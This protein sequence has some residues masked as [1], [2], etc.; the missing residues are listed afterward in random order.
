VIR[1]NS[2]RRHDY[3]VSGNLKIANNVRS[4]L[5]SAID[6]A[7]LEYVSTCTCDGSVGHNELVHAMSEPERD[8]APRRSITN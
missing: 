7:W 3:S 6:I 1:T 5:H 4:A 2:A 8:E